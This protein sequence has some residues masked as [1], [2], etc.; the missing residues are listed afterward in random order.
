MQ[1]HP[2]N[3]VSALIVEFVIL[4]YFFDGITS[5]LLSA[6]RLALTI[7][8]HATLASCSVDTLEYPIGGMRRSNR[9]NT[10]SV[11]LK[12]VSA[13]TRQKTTHSLVLEI[14]QSTWPVARY[15]HPPSFRNVK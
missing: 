15:S 13:A 7:R 2:Y 1:N 9:S 11:R 3:N 6:V 5:R 10:V 4:K 8:H 12:L 14:S